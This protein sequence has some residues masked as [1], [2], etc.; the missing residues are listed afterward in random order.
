MKRIGIFAFYDQSGK[1]KGYVKKL[2]EEMRP[3]L[4]DL[5]VVCNG[6]LSDDG[7]DDFMSRSDRL[8]LRENKG[9]DAGAYK[10]VILGEIGP[11]RLRE[12]DELLLFNNT[13]YG[14]V[15][16][17]TELFD[18]MQRRGADFW[19]ITARDAETLPFHIQSYFLLVT[20]KILTDVCFEEYWRTQKEIRSYKDAVY[21]FELRFTQFFLDHGYRAD[22]LIDMRSLRKDYG[23]A[24]NLLS[25]A[26]YEIV[27][28]HRCPIVKRK[29]LM[30]RETAALEQ[31]NFDLIRFLKEKTDYNTDFIWE[32]LIDLFSP[33]DL[34]TY[35]YLHVLLKADGAAGMKRSVPEEHSQ[36]TYFVIFSR[37]LKLYA[38]HIKNCFRNYK[39]LAVLEEEDDADLP[40]HVTVVWR[41]AQ[42]VW[43][44]VKQ[45]VNECSAVCLCVLTDPGNTG[46]IRLKR[47]AQDVCG[48]MLASKDHVRQIFD[49][50]HEQNRLGMLV[51]EQYFDLESLRALGTNNVLTDEMHRFIENYNWSANSQKG[52]ML[53]QNTNCFWC[54]TSIVRDCLLD[55]NLQHVPRENLF[56]LL[57]YWVRHEG[58][59]TGVLHN[60]DDLQKE[61]SLKTHILEQILMRVNQRSGLYNLEEEYDR[62]FQS[63]V[64][65][66]ARKHKGVYLYGAGQY[67]KV[68]EN[69]LRRNGIEIL[70]VV[71]SPGQ[72]LGR[73][74]SYDLCDVGTVN[75]GGGGEGIVVAMAPAYQEEV[76]GYL[77]R[78]PKEDIFFA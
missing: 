70:G 78:F 18:T 61:L 41:N 34:T 66:F 30:V 74:L 49:C 16:P 54:R 6:D 42:N 47:Y 50:F 43:G 39:I 38:A 32:D 3:F 57:P 45:F 19:G 20:K 64:M 17:L 7:R 53:L 59:Y 69:L 68:Y 36:E 13:F 26:G 63:G 75:L 44:C 56:A 9:Y 5:I 72:P 55:G 28:D 37:K 1:V 24:G 21:N 77:E 12:Y 29:H 14:P 52:E 15:Y 65:E 76:G 4:S 27:K 40:E 67:A 2:L 51:P 73:F 10:D 11:N 35:R 22:A 31:A 46:G 62:L 25:K 48:K 60:T 33:Y 8:I 71:V 23:A 58:C